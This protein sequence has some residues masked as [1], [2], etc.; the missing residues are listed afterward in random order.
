MTHP[1]ATRTLITGA[2]R[3]LGLEFARQCL[4]RGDRVYA[5]VRNPS[6]AVELHTLA[7][8]HQERL[9]VFPLDVT[10]PASL[11]K[12]R[13]LVGAETDW[14]DLLVNNAG[15]NSKALDEDHKNLRF[16]SLEASGMVTMFEV[17][18]V[19]PILVVQRFVD[20]LEKAEHPR[21]LNVSSW[22]GSI[23]E[24]NSGGNYAYCASKAA[25][26]M[27]TRTLAHDLAERDIITLAF[28]PGWVKTD[29]G[30]AK[31][32]LSPTQSVC[33]IL[34]TSD[35]ATIEDTGSFFQW[36]GSKHPW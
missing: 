36:D 25:L 21:L 15:I 2:G 19:A 28:N 14:L 18:A 9:F 22:L 24:K 3:G 31:A 16:G 17:N 1:H 4:D 32:H 13:D 7:K 33:G 5:G 20:L 6:A 29:M 12:A 35:T 27:L 8:T 23:A 30:G 26:N 10:D 11:E 34:G